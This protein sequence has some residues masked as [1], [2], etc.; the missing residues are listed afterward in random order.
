MLKRTFYNKYVVSFSINNQISKQTK[1]QP[2]FRSQP[3]LSFTHVTWII[4]DMKMLYTMCPGGVL[5]NCVTLATKLIDIW[6]IVQLI[7]VN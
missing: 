7:M 3:T 1:M 5:P 2:D 4:L 6:I